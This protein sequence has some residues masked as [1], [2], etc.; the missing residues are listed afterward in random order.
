[1]EIKQFI[2]KAIEGGWVPVYEYN[3]Q[4]CDDVWPSSAPLNVDKMFL[5]P[6]AWQ[7]VGKVE[8]WGETWSREIWSQEIS[9]WNETRRDLPEWQYHMHRMIDHLAEGGTIESYLETR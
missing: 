4:Y 5:D 9:A 3:C 6:L 1:M 8:G 7:A 2:Q